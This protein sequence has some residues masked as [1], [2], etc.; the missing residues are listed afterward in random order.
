MQLKQATMVDSKGPVSVTVHNYYH[1]L[2]IHNL[3]TSDLFM[4]SP[5][6]EDVVT[7]FLNIR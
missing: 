6:L 4:I 7:R 5:I 3:I 1:I 2:Y